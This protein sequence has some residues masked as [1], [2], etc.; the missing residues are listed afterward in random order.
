MNEH[1]IANNNFQHSLSLENRK[2]LIM[3]GIKDVESFDES[4]I[5]VYVQNVEV[6]IS[7]TGLQISNLNVERGELAIDGLIDG[8]AYSDNTQNK[9]GG[10]LSKIFR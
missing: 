7:G 2:K 9:N 6:C 3:T 4:K 1:Q 8:I 5:E 10:I